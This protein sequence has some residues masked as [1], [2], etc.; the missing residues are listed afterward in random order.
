MGDADCDP[1]FICQLLQVL[2]ENVVARTVTP[3]A[4]AE[5][6]DG[7]GVGIVLPA[8]GVPP[9]AKTITGEFAGIG[10]HSYIQMAMVPHQIKDSVGDDF[11]LG[12]TGEIV[13]KGFKG[14]L[15]IHPPVAIEMAQV[16]LLLGVDTEQGIARL[17]A[18]C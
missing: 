6:E 3:A 2:L 11:P 17:Q 14:G 10:A 18:L 5:H 16:L 1:N 8:V 12:P 13:I 4:V 9:M 15:A 7:R